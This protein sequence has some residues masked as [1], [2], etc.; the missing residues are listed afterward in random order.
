MVFDSP[1]ALKNLKTL[2]FKDR[3]AT[4]LLSS[5][6]NGR[7][8]PNLKCCSVASRY[9]W[10]HEQEMDIQKALEMRGGCFHSFRAPAYGSPTPSATHMDAMDDHDSDDDD[11]DLARDNFW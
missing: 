7:S 10:K 9:G 5:S 4:A 11:F 6:D 3:L 1:T 2:S 8:L